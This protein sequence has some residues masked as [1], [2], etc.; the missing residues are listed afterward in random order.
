[1]S[2]RQYPD[3][4]EVTGATPARPLSFVVVRYSDDYFHNLLRSDCVQDP[5]NQLITIDNRCNLFYDNLAEAINAGLDQAEH[6]LIVVAHEDVL[7]PRGWQQ[8]LERS[9]AELEKVDPNWGLLGSVGSTEGGEDK[10]HWSD[11]HTYANTFGEKSFELVERI[12]EQLMILRRS[13][14]VRLDCY[15]P[16]IHHIG[17]DVPSTLRQRALNTYVINAPTIHKF[18][19][20]TGNRIMRREDSPKIRARLD[21]AFVADM[22]CCDE[23][24]H[25]KWPDWR[26]VGFQEPDWSEDVFRQEVLSRIS[27][28]IVLLARGGSGSRLLSWL[29]EDAGIDLGNDINASG[30]AMEMVQA[31]YMGALNRYQHRAS[32]QQQRI[33]PRIRLAAARMLER[34]ASTDA[35]WGF[36][37]PESMLLLPEILQAFGKARCLHLVRDPLTTCLRRTHM[38]AR[39]DNAIGRVA[40]RAAYRYCGRD[41]EESLKDS[42]ALRMAYTTIH[43]VK[44][45]R[46]FARAHLGGRFLEIRFEDLLQ[47]PREMVMEVARWLGTRPRDSSKLEREVNPD[48]AA[49]PAAEYRYSPEVEETVTE[50]LAPLRRELGYI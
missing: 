36:K 27:Q 24:L 45:A 1:M 6:E 11:P 50:I 43:Q 46:D 42:P 37:L 13:H 8:Q 20:D 5:V 29:A 31:I 32:W 44:T 10:G 14:G 38:T 28:P 2:Q 41:L 25:W 19:D 39:F 21:P 35:P 12:D 16:S 23:Y 4:P 9:L 34:T 17:R 33:A 48:R 15:L 47:R 22:A 7:L 49:R 40:I 30:D 3:L 18:A 26:T